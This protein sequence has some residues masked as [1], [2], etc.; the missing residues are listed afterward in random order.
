[1]DDDLCWHVTYYQHSV[2]GVGS[3]SILGGPNVNIHC[4][5]AICAACMN[6]NKVSRVKYWLGPAP[7]VSTP[8]TIQLLQKSIA[9]AMLDAYSG[10]LWGANVTT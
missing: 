2:M 6:I 4:D 5:A 1:M 7:P 10:C 3:I 8:M 9:I